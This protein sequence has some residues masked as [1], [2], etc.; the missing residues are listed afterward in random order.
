MIIQQEKKSIFY[1][2]VC[3]VPSVPVILGLYSFYWISFVLFTWKYCWGKKK[4]TNRHCFYGFFSAALVSKQA[5]SLV[6][7]RVG[8]RLGERAG[9]VSFTRTRLESFPFSQWTFKVC[10]FKK[11]KTKHHQQKKQTTKHKLWMPIHD[12]FV[13]KKNNQPPPQL[14]PHIKTH[15]KTFIILE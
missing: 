7:V 11:K 2:M 12:H 9:S 8:K 6:L 3:Q 13:S 15:Y 14:Y 5:P 10:P 1:L 4:P